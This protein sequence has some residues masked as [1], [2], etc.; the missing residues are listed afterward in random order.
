[1]RHPA[2]ASR[3]QTLRHPLA[4]S[5]TDRTTS[6]PP[7]TPSPH[8]S[9]N[10]CNPTDASQACPHGDPPAQRSE[11]R[12]QP[13]GVVSDDAPPAGFPPILEAG[14]AA[15]PRPGTVTLAAVRSSRNQAAQP[16][17]SKIFSTRKP[18]GSATSPTPRG[19]HLPHAGPLGCPPPSRLRGLP[20]RNTKRPPTRGPRTE[21]TPR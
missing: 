1:M 6:T 18:T 7:R 5:Q 16:R 12:R 15:T 4:A 20:H 19:K 11:P 21:G 9:A 17:A 14:W 10:I 13:G 2:S 3:A 8:K